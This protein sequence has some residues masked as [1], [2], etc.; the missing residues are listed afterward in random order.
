MARQREPVLAFDA[1]SVGRGAKSDSEEIVVKAEGREE[2]DYE[3]AHGS[4]D[5]ECIQVGARH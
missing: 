2:G 4:G 3:D 1:G 5:A